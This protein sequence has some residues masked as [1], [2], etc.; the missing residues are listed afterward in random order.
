MSG[1][2]VTMEEFDHMFRSGHQR[3]MDFTARKYGTHRHRTIRQSLRSADEIGL[4]AEIVRGKRHPK[5]P[6]TSDDLIENN[7]NAML[8]GNRMQSLQVAMWRDEH[9]GRSGDRLDDNRSDRF[10]TV[11]CDQ[12]LK[13]VGK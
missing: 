5:P 3:I 6:E 2:G 12:A 4:G 1:V 13:V 8:L 10:C 7:E 9:A 11:Q